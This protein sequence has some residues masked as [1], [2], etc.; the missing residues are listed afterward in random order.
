MGP[1]RSAGACPTDM[2]FYFILLIMVVLS[3]YR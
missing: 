3:D 1:Q 2:I